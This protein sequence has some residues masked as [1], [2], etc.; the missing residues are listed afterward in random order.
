VIPTTGIDINMLLTPSMAF[1][2]ICVPWHN[3][4]CSGTVPCPTVT[5]F[6]GHD[7]L[8]AGVNRWYVCLEAFMAP[9]FNRIFSGP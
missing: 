5:Q 4:D 8:L 3:A 1:W 6:A 9:E 7:V 2:N